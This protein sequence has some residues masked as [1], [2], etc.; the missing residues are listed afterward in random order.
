MTPDFLI[1]GSGLAALSFA[2]LMARAGRSV[3]VL[4][5]HDKAGGYAHSFDVGGYRFNAQLHYVWNTAPDRTVGR[6]LARLG[7]ADTLPFVP[8]DPA[9]YDHMRIPGYALD[10]PGDLDELGRR[11]TA[12]FPRAA[13]GIRGF[14]DTVRLT[15]EGLEAFPPTWS[16]VRHARGLLRLAE[17]RDATL[18][19]VFDQHALPQEAQ[20]L[21]ALQWPDFL[22]PP[23]QLSFLAW[24]K[25]FCGYGRGAS[26]PKGHYDGVVDALVGVVRAA[27]GEVRLQRNVTRFLIEGG[28]VVGVEAETTDENGVGTGA[29]ERIDAGEVICNMDPQAAAARIGFEHF[30]AR[31]RARLQY[32]YS[33][34][35]FIAYCGVEG[36][37]LREHGFGA[38]NIFH[39]DSPDLNGLFAAMHERGDYRQIS[40]AMSTPTLISD[41]PGACPPG[42]QILELLTVAEHGRFLTARLDDAKAYRVAKQAIFD[43]MIEV[44]E[45]DYVPGLRGHLTVHVLGSPTTSERYARAPFG[46]SYGSAM[47]PRQVSR[48]RLDHRTGLPGLWFCNASAGFAGFAGTVWTGARLFEVLSGESVL[49]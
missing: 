24:V 48:D 15:D 49:G 33:P 27:G 41:A 20:A 47:T 17:V 34:S 16:A 28:R 30:P 4:E 29:F 25:L 31:V 39:A 37:D 11:L 1:V 44:I 35:S 22:L 2:A 14:L 9:G 18:Q 42:H 3:L 26:Y 5:A 38:W 46:N 6:V 36:L 8:L 45:R 23:D 13:D 21:L 43:R 19:H 7:L 40:F 12:L 32:T 10:I